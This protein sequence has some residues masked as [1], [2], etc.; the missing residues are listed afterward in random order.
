MITKI[1][2]SSQSSRTQRTIVRIQKKK[3]IEL[4]GLRKETEDK[5]EANTKMNLNGEATQGRSKIA[6]NAVNHRILEWEMLKRLVREI[7][8][9]KDR[10]GYKRCV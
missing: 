1:Q 8:G 10:C 9:I 2:R 6:I 7:T 4:I 3:R 5:T